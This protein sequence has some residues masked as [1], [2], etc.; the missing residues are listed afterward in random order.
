MEKDELEVITIIENSSDSHP[1]NYDDEKSNLKKEHD[2]L[3]SP[4]TK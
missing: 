1:V 3:Y 2:I 4:V